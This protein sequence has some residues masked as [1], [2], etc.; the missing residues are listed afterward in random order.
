MKVGREYVV[1]AIH[2]HG[3]LVSGL[4]SGT[5]EA[6]PTLVEQV[7]D[8]TGAVP[9]PAPD[10]GALLAAVWMVFRFFS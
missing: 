2:R 3:R 7:S 8:I 5:Q 4:C 1:F 6:S 10:F 9:A